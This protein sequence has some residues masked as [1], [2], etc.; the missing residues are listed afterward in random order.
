MEEEEEEE[1]DDNNAFVLELLL[2]SMSSRSTALLSMNA[3]QVQRVPAFLV[4]DFSTSSR[5]RV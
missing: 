2:S 3:S 1:E 5:L 4:S